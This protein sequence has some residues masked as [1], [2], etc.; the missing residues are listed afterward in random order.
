MDPLDR[1]SAPAADLLSQVDDILARAGAPDDH[2]LWTLLRRVRVLPGDAV[3]ALAAIRPAELT[4]AGVAVRDLVP[5]YEAARDALDGQV[6]WDGAAGDAY[7]AHART[8]SGGLAAAAENLRVTSSTA[9][10]VAAWL[11]D[12]RARL[13]AELAAVLSSAE[14][15]AV[16]LRSADAPPAAAAIAVRV[17]AA[18]DEAITS[19]AELALR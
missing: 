3:A 16:V 10:A 9:D 13:A 1:V 14:A 7:R 6:E 15:V 11:G 8:L 5:A 19:G 4:A 12:T 18:V 17:L 2:P